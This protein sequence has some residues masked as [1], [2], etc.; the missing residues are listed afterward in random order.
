MALGRAAANNEGLEAIAPRIC[1]SGG[2][3]GLGFIDYSRASVSAETE[4]PP[5][6]AALDPSDSDGL[7]GNTNLDY[8]FSL[9]KM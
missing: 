8:F 6:L 3:N 7:G 5:D 9:F 4:H 2:F 1:H